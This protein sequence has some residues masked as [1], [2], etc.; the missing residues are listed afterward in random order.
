MTR[1]RLSRKLNACNITDG[2]SDLY[3]I[4]LFALAL[5]EG[6][7]TICIDDHT[8][9]MEASTFEGAASLTDAVMVSYCFNRM[10]QKC[11]LATWTNIPCHY[12]LVLCI[13]MHGRIP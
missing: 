12:Y 2:C 3:L 9:C 6:N 11:I 7:L 13:F 8:L 4:Y 10:I 1:T 5:Q